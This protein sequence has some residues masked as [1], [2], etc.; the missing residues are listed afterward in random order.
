M[1][2]LNTALRLLAIFVMAAVLAACL[3]VG[4]DPTETID[5]GP[6]TPNLAQFDVRRIATESAGAELLDDWEAQ[7]R[8]YHESL[9]LMWWI[10]EILAVLT[11][12]SE[13]D[14]E[15]YTHV[16]TSLEVSWG[17][18]GSTWWWDLS[19]GEL[20]YRA[21]IS[22]SEGNFLFLVYASGEKQL[23]GTIEPN[24]TTGSIRIS[25]LFNGDENRVSD[26]SWRRSTKSDYDWHIS[27]AFIWTDA[28]INETMEIWT[29]ADGSEG[30]YTGAVW[31][32]P[33]DII[34]WGQ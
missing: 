9:N 27:I 32:D 26:F 20:D 21:E 1:R 6:Q 11:D 3:G 25:D 13:T 28:Q 4:E 29:T 33:Y 30:E 8:A 34:T 14:P 7:H 16:G 12:W 23:E 22:D 10:D 15:T 31:G 24:G 18:N 19:G 2:M 17:T 5:D